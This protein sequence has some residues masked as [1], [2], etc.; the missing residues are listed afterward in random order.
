MNMNNNIISPNSSDITFKDSDKLYNTKMLLEVPDLKNT[1]V[2]YLAQQY[3]FP[4]QYEITE[5]EM[6][7][8]KK[9]I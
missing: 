6:E 8:L 2:P 7:N 4:I 5:K 3:F 9:N 1:I